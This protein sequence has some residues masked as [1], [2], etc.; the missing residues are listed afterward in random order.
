M[1]KRIQNLPERVRYIILW[2]EV[3]VMGIVLLSWWGNG[4]VTTLQEM[5]APDIE[6]AF[7]DSIIKQSFKIPAVEFPSLQDAGLTPQL[8]E[9]LERELEIEQQ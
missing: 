3:G 9:E 5:R 1:L 8:I 7:P 2:G 6:Q 4:L